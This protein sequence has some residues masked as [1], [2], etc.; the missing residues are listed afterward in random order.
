M[1]GMGG[2]LA[3]APVSRHR[4]YGFVRGG[5]IGVNFNAAWRRGSPQASKTWLASDICTAGR[6]SVLEKR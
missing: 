6:T 3:V 4:A 1:T 5:L 2:S